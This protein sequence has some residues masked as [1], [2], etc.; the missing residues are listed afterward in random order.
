MAMK[1]PSNPRRN[2]VE[3]RARIYGLGK[4]IISIRGKPKR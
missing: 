2:P 3:K 1:L 4:K